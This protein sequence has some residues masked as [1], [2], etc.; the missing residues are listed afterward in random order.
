MTPTPVH[1]HTAPER[2][3][4][5][6]LTMIRKQI[7]GSTRWYR[8]TVWTPDGNG[9]VSLVGHCGTPDGIDEYLFKPRQSGWAFVFDEKTSQI[10]YYLRN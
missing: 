7:G 2:H 4:Q 6:L 5:I 3:R 10:D 8:Y 1:P 9:G